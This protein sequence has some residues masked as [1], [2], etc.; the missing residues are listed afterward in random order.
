MDVED[1][2]DILKGYHFDVIKESD[3]L[4]SLKGVSPLALYLAEIELFGDGFKEE[5]IKDIGKLYVDLIKEPSES[6]KNQ[7]RKAH[8]V[9]DFINE[10]E[11]IES[12]LTK[13][14]E[15]SGSLRDRS[16]T[17]SSSLVESIMHNL[18]E[19]KVHA[20]REE[21]ALFVDLK[22]DM[23]EGF[24]RLNMLSEEHDDIDRRIKKIDNLFRKKDEDRYHLLRELDGLSYLL[25]HHKFIEDY[26]LYPVAVNKIKDWRKLKE[27]AD[28]LGYCKFVPLP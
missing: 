25:H 2:K 7:I 12:F 18:N 22:K 19:I 1:V 21:E 5:D 9:V 6:L 24:G 10:H 14:D 13:L 3:A 27:R 20:T 23:G 15:V 8:P 17:L 26:L 4:E 16:K 11:E 28:E